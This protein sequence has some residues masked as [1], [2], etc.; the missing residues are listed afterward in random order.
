MLPP[1]AILARL[2]SCA[3][4]ATL[5]HDR[6]TGVVRAASVALDIQ[7]PSPTEIVWREE[8][9]RT[10]PPVPSSVGRSWS[11]LRWR[12]DGDTLHLAH[13]RFGRAH[14]VALVRFDLSRIPGL[15]GAWEVEADEPHPC[16]E[17][18][19]HAR[20]RGG[21]RP[22]IELAWTVL[23]PSK[24]LRIRTRYTPRERGATR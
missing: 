9:T 18:R 16:G 24:D 22:G 13:E 1:A 2:A 21:A 5:I 3:R 20:L 14:P 6:R 8:W 17:D 19:Y 23:G 11:V 7:T 4:A 10:R 12:L 15:L